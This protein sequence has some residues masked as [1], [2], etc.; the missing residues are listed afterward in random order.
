VRVWS[1]AIGINPSQSVCV[2]P[3]PMQPAASDNGDIDRVGRKMWVHAVGR[4][5]LGE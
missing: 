5:A 2:L 3:A 4:S 1:V